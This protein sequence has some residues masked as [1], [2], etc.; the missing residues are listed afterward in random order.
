MLEATKR[1]TFRAITYAGTSRNVEDTIV[2]AGAP[3]SGTTWV[4]E[5]L[6]ELND[7]KLFNEPLFLS[8]YPEAREAGF[9]WRTHIAPEAQHSKAE[10]YLRNALT[11][12][13]PLGPGWHFQ[14]SSVLG[15]LI[16]HGTKHRMV[17]KF[18]RAGR[19]LQWMGET[20]S[21]GGV[22]LLIRHP[23]A[24]ISSQLRHGRWDADQLVHDLESVDALG[25][26]PT[27]TFERYRGMFNSLSSRL[28]VM[29]AVW[30]L[31]YYIPLL[32]DESKSFPWLL[33]PYERLVRQ[34]H[35]ELERVGSF[36]SVDIPD[37]I[38]HS[39]DRPSFSAQGDVRKE[40][41]SQLR[42]WKDHLSESQIATILEIVDRF[43]LSRFYSSAPEPDYDILNRYQ[44]ANARW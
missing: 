1:A 32:G 29:T 7:Y 27:E 23:C 15:K 10:A 33:L 44:A 39:L 26:M 11:G 19:L 5:L 8:N 38:K 25:E 14:A 4:A 43:D 9:S 34:G 20:F 24:V 40:P 12:R 37:S 28:E 35:H 31:D 42:K 16:E 17:A 3:R 18:C 13:M 21:V 22:V 30:C 2:V 6:R 36:L 41:V